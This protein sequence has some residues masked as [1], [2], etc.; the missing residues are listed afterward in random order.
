MNNT[1]TQQIRNAVA[2]IDP[3]KIDSYLKENPK[4]K[5]LKQI[6]GYRKGVLYEDYRSDEEIFK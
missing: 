3:A 6:I 2:K 1:K 5:T 4:S